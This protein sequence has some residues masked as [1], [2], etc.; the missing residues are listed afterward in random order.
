MLFRN[1][2][3]QL[4]AVCFFAQ[5]DPVWVIGALDRGFEDYG[6][7]YKGHGGQD[8]ALD[9]GATLIVEFANGVRAL[10]CASKRTPRG[11][12]IDL[13]GTRGRIEVG[14]QETRAWQSA[15]DE[16]DLIPQP[17]SWT[18]GQSGTDLGERLVPG[19]AHLVRMVRYGEPA[20]SPPRAARHVL[21]IILGALHS[22]A[23]GMAPV[24]LPLPRH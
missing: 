20:N 10:V 18:Q 11:P 7:V 5:A 8:P 16:G 9:P 2:T 15:R 3:H 1:T 21:E 17:V 6:T 19:V 12:R 22:Q 14:E 13:L 24:K 4:A 23:Q